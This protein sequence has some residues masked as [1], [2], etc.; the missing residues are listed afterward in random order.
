MAI[1]QLVVDRYK[2]VG[3]YKHVE[4]NRKW[5]VLIKVYDT[6]KGQKQRITF[7]VGTYDVEYDQRLPGHRQFFVERKE[8]VQ[9]MLNLSMSPYE[10][11][12]TFKK[13]DGCQVV[14]KFV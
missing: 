8:A 5:G 10:I 7:E 2:A 13:I 6:E 3:F 12:Q 14:T 9:F 4:W 11:A 1:N